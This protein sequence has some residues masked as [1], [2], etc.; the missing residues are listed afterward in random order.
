MANDIAPREGNYKAVIQGVSSLDFKSTTNIGA[1]PS[2]HALLIDGSVSYFPPY[3][4]S[5]N[6]IKGV[7]SAITDTSSTQVIA[8]QAAG[9][10]IYV[11]ALLVTNSHA[12]VGTFVEILDGPTIIWKGYAAEVGGGFSQSFTVP[13]KG[14]AATALNAHC[15]TTGANVIVS[16]AG[17]IG[18]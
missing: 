18:A 1:N 7:T 11:T 12:T 6:F 14:T 2:T 5:D 8:A 15:V 9:I 13:L 10:R 4:T 3:T 16:A 17:Y